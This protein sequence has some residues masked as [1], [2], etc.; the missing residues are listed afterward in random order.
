MTA[1]QKIRENDPNA[2]VIMLTSEGQMNTV[3]QARRLGARDFIVKPCE[4]SRL[5]A[6]IERVLG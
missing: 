2:R 6:S 1:L 5:L 4:S 3:V